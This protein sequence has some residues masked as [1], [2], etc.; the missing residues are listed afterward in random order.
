[1]Q[2]EAK[3][4]AA[5]AVVQI[6]RSGIDDFGADSTGTTRTGQILQVID[7]SGQVVWSSNLRARRRPLSDVRPADGQVREVRA[8]GLPLL[9]DDDPYLMVIAGVES[10]G[11]Y[12]RAVV[13]IPIGPRTSSSWCASRR[14]G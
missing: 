7:T 12:H 6:R 2:E 11:V 3:N 14:Y 13:A 1:V 8:S 5:D 9:D 10:S 4:R